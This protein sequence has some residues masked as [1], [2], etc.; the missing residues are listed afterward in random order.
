MDRQADKKIDAS[1]T[2]VRMKNVNIYLVVF[3]ELG[4]LGLCNR[5]NLAV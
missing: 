1:I 4:K 5:Q 2:T 3:E